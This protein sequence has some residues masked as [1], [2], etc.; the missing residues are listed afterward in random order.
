MLYFSV[1]T[2]TLCGTS[3]VEPIDWYSSLTVSVQ[4]SQIITTPLANET[5]LS[6]GHTGAVLWGGGGGVGVGGGG[7]GG[8]GGGWGWGWGAVLIQWV[9]GSP[10]R[11]VIKIR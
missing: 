6:K 8:G 9:G 2:A 4:V 11:V 3:E 10:Y 5:A 1:S 7:G